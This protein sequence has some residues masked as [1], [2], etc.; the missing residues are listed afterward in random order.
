MKI[1]IFSHSKENVIFTFIR[2]ISKTQLFIPRQLNFK[3][4]ETFQFNSNANQKLGKQRQ[5]CDVLENPINTRNTEERKLNTH[6][7][8]RKTSKEEK[9]AT[10]NFPIQKR[11]FSMVKKEEYQSG[12]FAK[13]RRIERI[14]VAS[15][16]SIS[17][18]ELIFPC[19]EQ[20]FESKSHIQKAVF[21][22]T[23]DRPSIYIIDVVE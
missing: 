7:S 22:Y 4:T 19:R 18:T 11:K 14:F 8:R 9:M 2:S 21:T 10:E 1:I 23:T 15:T 13:K 5:F 17:L 3:G 6:K 20:F 16:F 12:N